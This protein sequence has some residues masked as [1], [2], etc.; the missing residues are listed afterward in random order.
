MT[1]QALFAERATTKVAAF[2]DDERAARNMA[3]SLETQ[4]GLKIDQVRVVQPGEKAYDRKLEPE[5]RAIART[6][7]R[8]HVLLGL[9]GAVVGVVL[10]ALLYLLG[11]TYI[12]S[13]PAVSAAVIIVFSF[14]IGMMLGG[15]VTARP[16]HQIVIQGVQ[17]A[18]QQGRW[19]LVLHPRNPRQ[20]DRVMT[21]L[22]SAG[23]DSVRTV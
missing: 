10:W 4:A 2:F 23:A 12:V 21:I 17:N 6:A 7:I 1:W 13:S 3:A 5:D 20:C 19:S 15:L 22:D 14:V 11:I 8:S 9:A 18:A 16:D